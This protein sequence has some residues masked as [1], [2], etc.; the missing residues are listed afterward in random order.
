MSPLG[1]V[2]SIVCASEEGGLCTKG[3]QN[4]ADTEGT[5]MGGALGNTG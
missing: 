3:I 5:G 1:P 2:G 4:L